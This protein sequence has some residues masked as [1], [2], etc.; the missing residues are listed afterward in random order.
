[1]LWVSFFLW[2]M[3]PGYYTPAIPNIL[4]AKGLGSDWLSYAFLAGPVAARNA[5]TSIRCT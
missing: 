5:P 1:M 2:G 3:A 4:A